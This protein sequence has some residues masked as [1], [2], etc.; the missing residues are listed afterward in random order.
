M[1]SEK[2]EEFK[3]C[4]IVTLAVYLL[5]GESKFV[6]TEDVAVKANEIAPG[7]FTWKKYKDQ[8]SFDHVRRQLCEARLSQN[9]DLLIGS[10]KHGWQ[11][12][13]KGQTYAKKEVERLV[14]SSMRTARLDNKEQMR[15]R[16]EKERLRSTNAYSKFYSHELD[17][18]TTAEAF[19]FFRI[20]EYVPA[21][22][23]ESKIL[24][25]VNNFSLD[26]EF[27]ELVTAM[28]KIVRE[29]ETNGNPKK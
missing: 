15:L 8:I 28:E 19:A 12:T 16:M 2:S 3:T 7:L 27:S 10:V 20:D 4:E 21:H 22:V 17:G 14:S 6:D 1:K 24:R 25:I 23:Q 13:K 29:V 11:L 9:G 26:T 18:V 5:G